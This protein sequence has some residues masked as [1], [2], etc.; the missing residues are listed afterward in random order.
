MLSL[1]GLIWLA[2][3]VAGCKK[4]STSRL[5]MMDTPDDTDLLLECAVIAEPAAGTGE[6]RVGC[7]I[8]SRDGPVFLS[9]RLSSWGCSFQAPASPG[10]TS[11]M[12]NTGPGD[13]HVWFVYQCE[14]GAVLGAMA[15]SAFD[16]AVTPVHSSQEYNLSD[17]L[18]R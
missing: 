17:R 5:S 14:R 2:A 18:R 3:G 11:R 6:G 15:A 10:V 9:D 7:R 1:L 13:W 12:E 4:R 16:C 8:V